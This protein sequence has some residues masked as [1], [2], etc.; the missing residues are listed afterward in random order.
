MKCTQQNCESIAVS[1]VLWPTGKWVYSCHEHTAQLQ[2]LCAHMG[3]HMQWNEL[4]VEEA[5]Y[6]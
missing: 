5:P 3:W 2:A 6:A 4:E 1:S